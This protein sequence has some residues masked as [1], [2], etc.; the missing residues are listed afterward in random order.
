[1]PPSRDDTALASLAVWDEGDGLADRPV[2]LETDFAAWAAELNS[3]YEPPVGA[4]PEQAAEHRRAWLARVTAAFAALAQALDRLDARRRAW[5][6]AIYEA[7]AAR[8]ATDHELA[9]ADLARENG[10]LLAARLADAERAFVQAEADARAALLAADRAHHRDRYAEPGEREARQAAVDALHDEA[11]AAA[12]RLMK[13]EQRA[14]RRTRPDP[15]LDARIRRARTEADVARR[16]AQVEQAAFDREPV[17]ERA[18]LGAVTASLRRLEAAEAAWAALDPAAPGAPG[19]ASY[20]DLRAHR[21][22]PADAA[23][24]GQRPADHN[25]YIHLRAAGTPHE[26][27]LTA[28]REAAKNHQR[29]TTAAP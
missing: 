14:A 24:V 12:V 4:T 26:D 15:E 16:Y 13:L 10:R 1:M 22:A 29:M 25:L 6:D 21:V 5:I 20:A 19:W 8:E 23:Q 7:A 17:D 2:Q 11:S 28:A 18:A 9:V 3:L 27:A